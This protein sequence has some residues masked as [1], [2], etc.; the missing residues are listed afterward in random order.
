M[1]HTESK[2]F[3]GSTVTVQ[4]DNIVTCAYGE[5]LKEEKESGVCYKAA[6]SNDVFRKDFGWQPIRYFILLK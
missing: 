6:S 5:V 2:N 3:F 1:T 4:N